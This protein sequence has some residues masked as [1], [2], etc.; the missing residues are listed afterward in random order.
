M[1]KKEKK[2]LAGMLHFI[3]RDQVSQGAALALDYWLEENGK[4][5]IV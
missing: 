3:S 1:W 2:K 5:E 4:W